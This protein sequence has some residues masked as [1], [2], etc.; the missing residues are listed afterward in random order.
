MR[1]LLIFL[2]GV[3]L[4]SAAQENPFFYT[5]TPF[6]TSLFQGKPLTREVKGF[7]D[8]RATLRGI[9]A[10]L[11]VKGLPQ[12]AT[13]QASIF[14]GVN[15]PRRLG[16]HLNGFPNGDLREL[17][18]EEGIFAALG[19]EGYRCS[20]LNAYRPQFFDKLKEGLPGLHY[21]CSTL[22]TYYGGLPFYS[23]EDIE[24]GKAL[25]M[26]LTNELLNDLGFSVPPITPEEA[27][28][29]LVGA[30]NKFDFS[31]F[32][33]FLSDRAGHLADR[34]RAG[35]VVRTLD[36]FLGAVEASLDPAQ[37]I[38]VVTSDHGN[39]EDL[40][41][42]RHTLNEVPL[43][44][45]GAESARRRAAPLLHDLTDILPAIRTLLE[46]KPGH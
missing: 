28:K 11:G 19:Q 9:D 29:R 43:M 45:M 3:G 30:S 23:L 32:E 6:L 16:Y 4:G 38:L 40:S 22:I 1:V 18:A 7:H 14:T 17:L 20:F 8:D 12:S 35:G 27:G 42:G 15:A 10:R 36:R 33:Y 37:T 39:I 13:G 25:F 34:E 21:S 31:L 24:A 44:L 26:D 46:F 5:G 41:H 2:D